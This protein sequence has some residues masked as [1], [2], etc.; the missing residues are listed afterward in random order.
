M[1]LMLVTLFVGADLTLAH[2]KQTCPVTLPTPDLDLWTGGPF[3]NVVSTQMF[4]HEHVWSA[5]LWCHIAGECEPTLK[6]LQVDEGNGDVWACLLER[7]RQI[8]ARL[9]HVTLQTGSKVSIHVP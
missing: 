4:N 2:P 3:V 7:R 9:E 5:R 1:S 6:S 8:Q